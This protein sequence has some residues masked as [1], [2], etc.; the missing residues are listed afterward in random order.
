MLSI[1]FVIQ[2]EKDSGGV[3]RDTFDPEEM[4]GGVRAVAL[5]TLYLRGRWR[6]A[7]TVLNGSRPFRDAESAP[8]R[9]VRMIRINDLMRYASLDDWHFQESFQFRVVP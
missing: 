9:T 8:H 2:V 3:I 1:N 4:S 6:A 7:P 5:T